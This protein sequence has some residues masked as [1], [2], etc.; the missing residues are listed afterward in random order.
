M[1]NAI[2]SGPGYEILEH[3]WQ[4]INQKQWILWLDKG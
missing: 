1:Y 3:I 4:M 2:E